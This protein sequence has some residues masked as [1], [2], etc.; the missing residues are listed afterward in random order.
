MPSFLCKNIKYGGFIIEGDHVLVSWVHS[1]STPPCDFRAICHDRTFFFLSSFTCL[2]SQLA[3]GTQDR[4]RRNL[5]RCKRCRA[6]SFSLLQKK[7]F[8]FI[9]QSFTKS[10]RR[11]LF[12]KIES[13]YYCLSLYHCSKSLIFNSSFHF[14]SSIS[15][16]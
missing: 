13:F 12:R 16:I 7:L 9:V 8:F 14:F 15:H 3:S 6:R 2:R 10:K 1:L 11:K 4:E 5:R